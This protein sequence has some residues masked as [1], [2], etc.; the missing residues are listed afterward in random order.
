MAATAAAPQQA[1]AATPSLRAASKTLGGKRYFAARP[2]SAAWST[3]KAKKAPK[4]S[5]IST[6]LK[7]T[8]GIDAASSVPIAIKG[9]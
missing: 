8:T 3:A 4:C 6:A 5:L 2:A 7:P 9:A 1:P